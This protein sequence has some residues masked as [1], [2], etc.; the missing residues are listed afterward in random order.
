MVPIDLLLGFPN[1]QITGQQTELGNVCLL[2]GNAKDASEPLVGIVLAHIAMLVQFVELAV[3]FRPQLPQFPVRH[4]SKGYLG[5]ALD[6]DIGVACRVVLTHVEHVVA[7]IFP[8]DA[9]G[10]SQNGMTAAVGTARGGSVDSLSF[11]FR[12]HCDIPP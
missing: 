5:A 12:F 6:T 1:D 4:S 10:A 7:R 9:V 11:V 3:R 2:R 8:V